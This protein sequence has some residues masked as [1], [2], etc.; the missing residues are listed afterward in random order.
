MTFRFP[1]LVLGGAVLLAL[2]AQGQPA[3]AQE[4][5]EIDCYKPVLPCYAC[6]SALTTRERAVCIAKPWNMPA[7]AKDLTI[8]FPASPKVLEAAD[9]NYRAYCKGCH[10]EA[11]DGRGDVALKFELPSIS[12]VAP[13][14]QAQADGELFWKISTGKGAMP[15][16]KNLMSEEERWQ[17]VHYVRRLAAQKTGRGDRPHHQPLELVGR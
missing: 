13:T 4:G 15:A 2:L 7:S 3:V 17:M 16:W 5:E 6:H 1:C 11:G 14:V 12:I 10:G 9:G 8:P